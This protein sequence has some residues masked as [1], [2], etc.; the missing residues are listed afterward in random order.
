[1]KINMM[2]AV[3]LITVLLTGCI[4]QK[5]AP[6]LPNPDETVSYSEGRELMC[7]TESEDKAKEIAAI[8]GIELVEYR[9]ELAVFH[10][11]ED[12]KAVIKRGVENGWLELEG[13]I[14]ISID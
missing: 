5:P 13:N 1:M 12:P 6:V 10:T 14:M 3:L 4:K 9:N 8:Y 2:V 7:I 11:E